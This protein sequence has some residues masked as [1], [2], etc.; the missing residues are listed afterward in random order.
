MNYC[1]CSNNFVADC[2]FDSHQ[3][4]ENQAA[5]ISVSIWEGESCI[6]GLRMWWR[7]VLVN[8]C[9]YAVLEF[10]YRLSGYQSGES[11]FPNPEDKNYDDVSPDYHQKQS[12]DRRQQF[13]HSFSPALNTS[14][15]TTE[16]GSLHYLAIIN[17][18]QK[19]NYLF[20][21]RD[22]PTLYFKF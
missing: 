8:L 15:Q 19:K 11:S 22:Y 3:N 17:D 20:Q 13:L 6:K 7:A 21:K 9:D 12:P 4:T 10:T 5:L 2:K 1:K 16:R 18:G 14:N